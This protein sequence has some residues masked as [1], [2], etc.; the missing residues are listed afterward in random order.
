MKK[1]KGLEPD[2][3]VYNEVTEEEMLERAF[4][5]ATSLRLLSS[6]KTDVAYDTKFQVALYDYIEILK[7]K[8]LGIY[9][10]NMSSISDEL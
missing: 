1:D 2:H 9:K 7:R 4:H 6:K 8:L 3:H 10:K 5:T